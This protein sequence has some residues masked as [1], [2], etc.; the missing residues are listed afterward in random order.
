MAMTLRLTDDEQLAL[1]AQAKSDGIS[2][3][4][5][6]RQAIREYVVRRSHETSVSEA[7]DRIMNAHADAL[8]RLGE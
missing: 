5:A 8:R 2:M 4:V 1:Q 3:Q 6:A 7:A